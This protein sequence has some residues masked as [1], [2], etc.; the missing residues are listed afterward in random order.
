MHA[1]AIHASRE[2]ATHKPVDRRPVCGSSETYVAREWESVLPHLVC[3]SVVHTVTVRRDVLD[4]E[5]KRL[6]LAQDQVRFDLPLVH[7]VLVFLFNALT[8]LL[9]LLLELLL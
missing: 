3:D 2:D 7:C 9:F 1:N 6:E 5:P 8:P 4:R